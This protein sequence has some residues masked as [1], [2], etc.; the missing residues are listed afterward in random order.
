MSA[1]SATYKKSFMVLILEL[2][3]LRTVQTLFYSQKSQS[4][5][6]TYINKK[7]DTT[8]YLAIIN[9]IN[10][11]SHVFHLIFLHAIS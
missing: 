10:I 6:S 5:E 1:N 11:M 7:N 9:L 2:E 8:D 4:D 3:K